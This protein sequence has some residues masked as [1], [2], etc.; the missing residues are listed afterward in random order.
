MPQFHYKHAINLSIIHSNHSIG[1]NISTERA[2]DFQ[3]LNRTE[4][5]INPREKKT[6][7]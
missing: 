2:I 3:T 7:T 6:R 5:K 1:K 4:I